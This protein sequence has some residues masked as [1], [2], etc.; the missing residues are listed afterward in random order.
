MAERRLQGAHNAA[1]RIFSVLLVIIGVVM[2]VS[3]I[4]RGGGPLA[5]GVVFGL[6]FTAA[7]AV[8]L[9]ASTRSSAD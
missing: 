7:G 9:Y 5:S 8:R 6:L 1:T 4:A 3:T 2:L